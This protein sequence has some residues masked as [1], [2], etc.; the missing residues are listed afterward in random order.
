LYLKIEKAKGNILYTE[1]G[2]NLTEDNSGNLFLHYSNDLITG[3]QGVWQTN[4]ASK[5][6]DCR[7]Q[8]E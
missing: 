6:I 2:F 8:Q 5:N 7:F 1:N 4:G 3:M